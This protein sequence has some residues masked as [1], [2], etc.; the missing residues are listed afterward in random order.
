M[1]FSCGNRFFCGADGAVKIVVCVAEATKCGFA[2]LPAFALLQTFRHIFKS[3]LFVALCLV[4]D[5]LCFFQQAYGLVDFF[6]AFCVL[7]S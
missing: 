3:R 4:K 2:L 5:S 6:S 7:R 1:V